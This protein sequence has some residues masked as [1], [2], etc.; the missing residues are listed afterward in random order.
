M[1]LKK[2]VKI[3]SHKKDI[4]TYCGFTYV[5]SMMSYDI[6]RYHFFLT[7]FGYHENIFQI[8]PNNFCVKKSQ[9]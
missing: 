6:L 8:F 7:F 9:K 4:L 1:K 2:K 3:P 5:E